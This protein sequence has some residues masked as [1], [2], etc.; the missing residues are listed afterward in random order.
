M[1]LLYGERPLPVF[2]AAAKKGT[3][4]PNALGQTQKFGSSGFNGNAGAQYA[5]TFTVFRD[6]L[7]MA[8][9]D[10]SGPLTPG[11]NMTAAAWNLRATATDRGGWELN[12]L[13]PGPVRTAPDTLLPPEAR[14]GDR[15]PPPS[16]LPRG[17]T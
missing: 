13:P 1:T 10:S 6:S 9:F 11:A 15:A 7:C 5:W 16:A 17:R 14:P 2:D 12:R 8:T 4:R 3:T